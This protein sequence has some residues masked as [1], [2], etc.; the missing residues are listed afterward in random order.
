M[1][2]FKGRVDGIDVEVAHVPTDQM[3]D[4]KYKMNCYRCGKV[5]V[6][7]PTPIP[8]AI[9][10]EFVETPCSKCVDPMEFYK[11]LRDADERKKT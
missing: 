9:R 8:Q 11:Q 3:P 2:K 6:T 4:M 1:K 10:D 7:S 5:I